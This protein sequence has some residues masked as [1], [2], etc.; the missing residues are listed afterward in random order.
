[1]KERRRIAMLR[2]LVDPT[3]VVS[4]YLLLRSHGD[5]NVWRRVYCVL[6]EDRLWIIRRMK[7]LTD[8]HR[9]SNRCD[10]PEND[11][12]LSS[13]RIGRHSYMMLHRALLLESG[14]GAN[15][16]FGKRLPNTFRII[17]FDG[18]HQTFRAF[19]S[20]SFKI[21]TSSL[22]EK[23]TLNHSH[24][25][26]ELAGVIAEDEAAALSKRLN[27]VAVSPLMD[28]ML[29]F[30]RPSSALSDVVRFGSTVAEYRRLHRHVANAVHRPGKLIIRSVQEKSRYDE[31]VTMVSAVWEDARVVASKSAQLLHAFAARR[32]AGVQ[33]EGENEKIEERGESISGLMENLLGEQ[34]ALQITLGKRW[35]SIGESTSEE[36][37]TLPPVDLFYHLLRLFQSICTAL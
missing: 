34:K 16:P 13:F 7:T 24:G 2:D 4:G 23:I 17:P 31:N 36:G 21:W 35:D 25:L 27:D 20:S 15:S 1:M 29:S 26:M 3:F 10:S 11:D 9:D 19:N 30:D 18:P 28:G 14:D 12:A 37:L 22:A 33:Q 6:G 8:Q 5:C 32:H